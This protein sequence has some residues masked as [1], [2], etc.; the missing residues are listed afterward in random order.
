MGNVLGKRAFAVKQDGIVSVDFEPVVSVD[1][2]DP[3]AVK[4]L[5]NRTSCEEL[6]LDT[7]L[8]Q[9]VFEAGGRRR[10]PVKW[11]PCP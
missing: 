4:L 7:K 8:V 10:T 9:A 6:G 11:E 3:K 5:F 1:A 2:P